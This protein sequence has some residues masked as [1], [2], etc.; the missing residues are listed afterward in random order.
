MRARGVVEVR[1]RIWER[2]QK[3]FYP[4]GSHREQETVF[5]DK[6]QARSSPCARSISNTLLGRPLVPLNSITFNTHNLL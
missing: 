1:E 5:V 3:K 6:I 2:Q 4:D